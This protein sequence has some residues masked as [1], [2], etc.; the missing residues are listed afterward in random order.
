MNRQEEAPRRVDQPET[1]HFL[2]RLVRGGP[3]VAARIAYTDNLWRATIDGAEQD[4]PAPEWFRAAGV[5]RIWIG[6]RRC[7]PAEYDYHLQ[8]ARWARTHS[9]D[10]PAAQ[11]EKPIDLRRLPPVF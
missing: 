3:F 1:G 9:P 7:T 2:L 5:E 8:L 4:P 11:P 10:H 6:G